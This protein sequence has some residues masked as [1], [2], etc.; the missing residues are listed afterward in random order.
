VGSDFDH[1]KVGHRPLDGSGIEMVEQE[2]RLRVSGLQF[3]GGFPAHVAENVT[4]ARG[5]HDRDV[6][7]INQL[8]EG[9]CRLGVARVGQDLAINTDAVARG[10]AGAVVQL[11]RLVLVG[12][13][14]WYVTSK[15]SRI[16]SC[17][18]CPQLTSQSAS[19]LAAKPSGPTKVIGRLSTK[20]L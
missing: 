11:D 16:A 17:Q 20:I 10:A 5:F 3:G 2:S 12:S 8:I 13:A 18:S 1:L 19:I 7:A 14:S 9:S 6:S 15:R 4:R